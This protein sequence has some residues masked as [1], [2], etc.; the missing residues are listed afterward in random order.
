MLVIIA[1]L[2]I[3]SIGGASGG[4]YEQDADHWTLF[5]FEERWWYLSGSSSRAR[6]AAIDLTK[7]SAP[8]T[9]DA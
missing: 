4:A 8:T 7:A 6:N 1:S 3:R 9:R 5:A 2:V